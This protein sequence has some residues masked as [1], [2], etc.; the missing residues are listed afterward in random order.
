MIE[1][2][3]AKRLTVGD[4]CIQ[5]NHITNEFRA[6]FDNKTGVAQFWAV[7]RTADQA[8]IDAVLAEIWPAITSAGPTARVKQ[9]YNR[10]WK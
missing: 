5:R 8:R 10:R 2:S 7:G 9:K 6:F 3:S 4:T 1:T